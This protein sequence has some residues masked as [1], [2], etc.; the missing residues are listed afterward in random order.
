M[1]AANPTDIPQEDA[2]NGVAVRRAA[3]DRVGK[4]MALR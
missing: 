2:T 3:L 1:N 4:V